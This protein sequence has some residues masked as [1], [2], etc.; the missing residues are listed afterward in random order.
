M[1]LISSF[2]L[3]LLAAPAAAQVAPEC[4]S[5]SGPPPKN[6][7]EGVQQ[8]FLKNYVA[9]ATT[10]SPLHGPIPSEPGHGTSAWTWR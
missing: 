6:Y 8:D 4:K 3:L 9:L 7:D 10:F 2:V 1:R 5:F